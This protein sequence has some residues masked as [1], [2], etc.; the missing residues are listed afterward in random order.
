VYSYRIKKTLALL[1]QIKPS[2]GQQENL[3]FN[4]FYVS[5]ISLIGRIGEAK[6]TKVYN[7]NGRIFRNDQE[8]SEFARF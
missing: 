5:E 1:V 3:Q 4:V 8:L 6:V 2:R 7:R